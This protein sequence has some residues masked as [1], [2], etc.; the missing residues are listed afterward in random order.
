MKQYLSL[1]CI[2]QFFFVSAQAQL[3]TENLV[4]VTIDGVR[5]REVFNGADS[6]LVNDAGYTADP[7]LTQ[8]EFW[9]SSL[10]ERRRKLLPFFWNI[11]VKQGSLYGNRN[12]YNKV[13]VANFYKFSYPG[14]NELFTGYADP[15]INSNKAIEDNNV[16]VFEFLN[17]VPGY[18][19]SVVAFTSWDIFPSILAS[20]RNE[21]QVY[22][23]YAPLPDSVLN[24]EA[25][26]INQLQE[27][28]ITNKKD[29]RYDELTFLAATTYLQQHHPKVILVSFG[30]PDESAHAGEYDKYLQEINNAD[31]MIGRLWYFI[32]TDTSYKNKTA[33]LITTD[34]GRGKKSNSWTGHGTF[35]NGSRKTWLGIIGPDINPGGEIKKPGK[36]FEKQVAASMASLLG[37]SF[38][39]DHPVA[40]PIDFKK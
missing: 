40:K 13:N 15:A 17:E 38:V 39:T 24:P 5:W 30:E 36:L 7:M 14:Y 20:R 25:N 12:F 28:V 3:K 2:L 4:I 27:K 10:S 23:G 9:D 35:I 6:A 37:L 19:D 32:Q 31:R 1:L 29:T 34:H 11:L 18:K 33:L 22:S 8:L 26:L 21:L 16:N